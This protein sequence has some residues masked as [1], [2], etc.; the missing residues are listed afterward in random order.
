MPRWT[1]ERRSLNTGHEVRRKRDR[2]RQL[3]AAQRAMQSN[4]AQSLTAQLLGDPPPGRS[5]LDQRN[6]RSAS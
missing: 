1:D 4:C 3:I 6:Q 2:T 5:A